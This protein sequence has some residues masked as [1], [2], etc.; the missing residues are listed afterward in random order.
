MIQRP[1]VVVAIAALLVPTGSWKAVAQPQ[2]N[3]TLQTIEDLASR[4]ESLLRSGR[5]RD[6]ILELQQA[7]ELRPRWEYAYQIAQAFCALKD[8]R[9]SRQ[10]FEV[11]RRDAPQMQIERGEF[12]PEPWY[13]KPWG[14]GLIALGLL[15]IAAASILAWRVAIQPGADLGIFQF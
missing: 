2:P 13:K 15:T 1:G 14:I 7:Y 12:C 6:G 5:L 9:A 4:G 8:R 10:W 11:Y 3:S